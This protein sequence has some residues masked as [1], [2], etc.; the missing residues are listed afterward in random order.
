MI[1]ERP[2][3]LT[4]LSAG[5]GLLLAVF[6]SASPLAAW[7]LAAA[8][9]VCS[10]AG[11]GLARPERR[12]LVGVLAAA[13]VTRAAYVGALVILGIPH[14]N[15]MSVGALSGDE[16]Y[17]LSRALRTRDI[18]LGFAHTTYD[19]F[20]AN[21]EYGRTS[22][23]RL[24]TWLQV[25]F[26]P[27]PYSMRLLNGLLYV[28]GASVLFRVVRPSFGAVPAL[29]GLVTLLF[30]PSLFVASVS[31]LKESL[32]FL[33]AAVLLA[34]V[35]RVRQLRRAVPIAA[36]LAAAGACLWMMNDLRRGALVLAL[37][38]LGVGL[39]FR[40]IGGH[41]W[42]MVAAVAILAVGSAAALSQPS[43]RARVMDGIASA[44]KAHAGHVFTVGHSYKLMDDGFYATPEEPSGWDLTLSGPQAARFVVRG[45]I[46]FLVTPFPWE[47]RSLRELAFLP[48]HVAW[49][50]VLALLPAG[51]AAG[52]RRDAFLT[53]LLLGFALPTAA[54]LALT[55][56]NVGTLLRLRGLVT[57]Y[58]VWLSALG[59]CAIL[60]GLARRQGHPAPPLG[61]R[62]SESPIP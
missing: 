48:E 13:L 44:A 2:V 41:R 51:V 56:G 7:V 58:L 11:R 34:S 10:V 28:G 61:A 32:Y 40:L 39:G 6:Y 31:L 30:L 33:V 18:A 47:M 22:Y 8:A 49:Y 26:G 43:V 54:V 27:T 29:A 53:S 36:S 42:R 9:A 4:I 19:Y 12:L 20:V 21:D 16:A 5:A 15:T 57:P 38:G 1:C 45:V 25:V 55:T 24:L 23:L 62:L 37:A 52:W 46:S 60:D 50:V 17:Y 59:L 14:H 3:T 35:V